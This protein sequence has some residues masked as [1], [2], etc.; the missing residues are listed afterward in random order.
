MTRQGG[1]TGGGEDKAYP[2]E[3]SPTI[4]MKLFFIN[5]GD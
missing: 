5:M 2:E 3:S 1:G 4:Y